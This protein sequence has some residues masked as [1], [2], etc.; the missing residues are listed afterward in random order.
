MG[1]RKKTDSSHKTDVAI[2]THEMTN[3]RAPNHYHDGDVELDAIERLKSNILMLNDLQS[4]LHFMNTELESVI[5]SKKK[6]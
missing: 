2:S 4:R 1:L 6:S 3:Y 5:G